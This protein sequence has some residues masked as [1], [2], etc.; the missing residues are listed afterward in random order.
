MKNDH[1]KPTIPQPYFRDGAKG[2]IYER[3]TTLPG[4]ESKEDADAKMRNMRQKDIR[5]RRVKYLD[6]YF[7]YREKR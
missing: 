4:Y 7:I 3:D 6:K 5:V 1:L 2:V